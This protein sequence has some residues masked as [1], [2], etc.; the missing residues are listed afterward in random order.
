MLRIA[1]SQGRS[2]G[3]LRANC[4]NYFLPRHRV[5]ART[6]GTALRRGASCARFDT[7]SDK[8]DIQAIMVLVIFISHLSR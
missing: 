4:G 8:I 3:T 2:S 6:T 1:A 5:I 7:D